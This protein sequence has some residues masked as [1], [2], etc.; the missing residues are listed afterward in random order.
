MERKKR[1]QNGGTRVEASLKPL[2]SLY[3]RSDKDRE[4]V[5]RVTVLSLRLHVFPPRSARVAHV[6]D[7]REFVISLFQLVN[8]LNHLAVV[9]NIP[10]V[11]L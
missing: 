8:H 1:F 9:N 10:V 11:L 2:F 7:P 3:G 6:V 4:T 5:H